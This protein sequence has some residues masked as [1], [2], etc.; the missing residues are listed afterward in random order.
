MELKLKE[1]LARMEEGEGIAQAAYQVR[2]LEPVYG[3]MLLAGARSGNLDGVVA[4]LGGLLQESMLQRVENLVAVLDPVLSGTMMVTV[5]FAL[6]SVM[7]PLIGMM[8]SIG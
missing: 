2:L 5:G 6:L 7:L 4:R 8:N 1:C 3:R